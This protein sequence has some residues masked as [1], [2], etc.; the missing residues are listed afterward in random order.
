[1]AESDDED[2]LKR[3]A[4]IAT[5]RRRRELEDVALVLSSVEGRRFYWRM[6]E[7]CGIHKSSFTGNNTTFFNE[8]ERNIGLLLLADLEEA[9]P[10]AYVKCLK[11]ARKE[12]AK[13][14]G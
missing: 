6:L 2:K 12:E 7:R 3:K 8:G 10:D 1:M 13:Y 11:E 14:N 9:D 5:V 4:S